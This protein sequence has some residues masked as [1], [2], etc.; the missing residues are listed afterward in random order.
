VRYKLGYY[1][2]LDSAVLQWVATYGYLAIFGLLVL[3]I[4]GLPVPDE[5][6]LGGC[7]FLIYRGDLHAIPTFASALAGSICGIT[8]SYL[9]GR[10][11]GW[12]FLHSRVGRMLHISDDQIRRVHDW[13]NRIG[14]WTLMA[15]YFVPGVRH[16]TGIVAGTSKL[17]YSGFA[18][19]AYGG[20][21]LWVSTFLFIGY[22]FGQRWEQILGV[23]EHNLKEASIMAAILILL[24]V[25]ILYLRRFVGSSKRG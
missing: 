14:H 16:F 23:I 18:A 10:T 25:V 11:L 22:H 4:V 21:L 20:A 12:K 2:W 15:G 13:F 24:Y 7:G 5:F 17:E 1:R 3:G 19:F 9:I 8:C 6:L